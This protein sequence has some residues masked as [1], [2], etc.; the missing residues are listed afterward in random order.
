VL[1][2][3]R[4]LAHLFWEALDRVDYA[5]T[6]GRYWLIDRICGPEPSTP[7]DKQREAKHEKL[8]RA[9]PMI[10]L[11]GTVADDA[12]TSGIV[13]GQVSNVTSPKPEVPTDRPVD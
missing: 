4:R 6:L 5:V 10:G 11:D 13:P 2:L 7:A 9:F 3:T 1:E 12:E 8:K